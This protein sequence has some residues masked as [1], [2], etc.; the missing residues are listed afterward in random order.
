MPMMMVVR[1]SL[2]RALNL[3]LSHDPRARQR[4]QSVREKCFRLSVP[5]LPEPI[6]VFFQETSVQLLG[7][8]YESVDGS[9]TVALHDLAELQDASAVTRMIQQGRISIAGDPVFAQQA[10]QVFLQINV[11]WEEAFADAFG[12]V[13]GYWLAQGID[14]LKGAMPKAEQMQKRVSEFLT[15]ESTLAASPVFFALLEDD[16]KALERR[17]SALEKRIKDME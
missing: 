3:A 14:R 13:P 12:D 9:V 6:T 2:E 8:E 1:A 4:L 11:D 10:A 17:L 5:E 7:P 16:V 15:Q